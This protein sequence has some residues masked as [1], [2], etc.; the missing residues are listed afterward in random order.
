M[1]QE[2]GKECNTCW[3]S[4]CSDGAISKGQRSTP[5][6]TAVPT[7]PD[8]L[9]LDLLSGISFCMIKPLHQLLL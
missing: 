2:G 9:S 3:P 8:F 1:V 6:I 5:S 7:L 4:I